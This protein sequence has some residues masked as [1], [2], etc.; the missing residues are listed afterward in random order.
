M[1]LNYFMPTRVIMG[2]ECIINNKEIFRNLGTKAMIV[3]GAN[4]AKVNGS[5]NDVVTALSGVGIDYIIYDK[6]MSNPTIECAYEGAKLA[7]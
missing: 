3:T 4:S 5:E 6:V 2:R 1:N 7:K